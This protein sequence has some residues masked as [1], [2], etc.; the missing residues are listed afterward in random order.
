MSRLVPDYCPA[1]LELP[2]E[3]AMSSLPP[4]EFCFKFE[5]A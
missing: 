1:T 3:I 2:F 5:G 4:Q